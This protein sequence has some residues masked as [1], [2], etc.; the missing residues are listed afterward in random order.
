MTKSPAITLRV[1]QQGQ[2]SRLLYSEVYA[3]PWR[4]EQAAPPDEVLDRPGRQYLVWRLRG[5]ASPDGAW[6]VCSYQNTQVK[7][8]RRLPGTISECRQV[9][10]TDAKR[11]VKLLEQRCR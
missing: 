3:G 8:E 10:S 11:V 2:S 1:L 5:Q 4:N 9:N 6:L 7:L